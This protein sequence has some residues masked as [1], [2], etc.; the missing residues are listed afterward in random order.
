MSTPNAAQWEFPESLAPGYKVALEAMLRDRAVER[1][2]RRDTTLWTEDPAVAAEIRGRLGWLDA[3]TWLRDRAPELRAFAAEVRAAGFTRV[4]LLG[5][6]GSSLAADVLQLASVPGP[7]AP[8]LD[9]L[10]STDP[11]TVANAEASS[12][13]DHTFFLVSSKSGGTIETL[14]QYRYFR[15]RVEA[16]GLPRP[17]SRFAAI[18][19]AGSPLER[20]AAKGKF[21][22]VFLNPP[23]VG[24]RFSALTY[25][26]MVPGA[27]SGLDLD[28]LAAR[29]AS[30]QEESLLDDPERNSALRLA[31]FLAA[32]ARA[33]RDKLTLLPSP[34]L[35]ALGYWIEQLV[36]ESTGKGG[37]GV[38]PVE[39][40]PL[41]PA[42]HYGPD[43]V[44]VSIALAGETNSD[45]E[46]LEAD[47]R[48][49]GAPWVRITLE[50]RDQLAGEFYRW[51]VAVALLG[52]A[53]GINPFDQPNVEE[54]KK[55]T[56][57]ILDAPGHGSSAA[58]DQ[59]RATDQGVEIH[60]PDEVWR[61]L[62][63]ASPSL[64]SLEM[65]LS[66]FFALARSGDYLALLA[67][68]DRTAAS[69][70][71]FALI[72]R[73]A[74]NALHLPVL[75]GYGPRY[76]HSI[77]QLFKGG[78]SGGLFLLVTAEHHE[79]I[80]IPGV[81]Y[82]FGVLEEAQAIGDVQALT[83]RGKPVIRLHLTQGVEAGLTAIAHAAERALAAL[84][85]V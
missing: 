13:L 67:Y 74:R 41:G 75:Q 50:N 65:V 37:R 72:R 77:G 15:N 81:P 70:A 51:E 6:G 85:S 54:S 68:L 49:L 9:V 62:L 78:P 42:H 10:D 27:L 82:T 12:R 53:M 84:Q 56:L 80:A 4:L 55:I 79:D 7:G 59:P 57:R 46:H 52:A 11:D 69:E 1:L 26:G 40:E 33:G 58:E 3:P 48:R 31:A 76:L 17:G 14:S 35:R 32:A 22:H 60:A 44:F 34:A 61:A 24:G 25:F 45:V 83:G 36:A 21:R 20:L 71:A 19:D 63:G 66:R 2:R 23:D 16:M 64:P 47:V 30:A 73:A 29:A 43:R 8:V 5:M 18:T 39:G 38:L 28:A